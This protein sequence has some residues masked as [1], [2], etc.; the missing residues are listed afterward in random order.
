M[1]SNIASANAQTL[2]Q[3]A[4][5][6]ARAR[7]ACNHFRS[8]EAFLSQIRS[9]DD[10]IAEIIRLLKERYDSHRSKRYSIAEKFRQHTE[11]LQNFSGVMDIFTQ[12]LGSIAMSVWAPVKF[13]LQASHH[14]CS[15]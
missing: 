8:E 13:V 12:A 11:W 5:A 6:T 1:T 14:R 4:F 3:L 10:A 15:N 9:Q 7:V 2:Q